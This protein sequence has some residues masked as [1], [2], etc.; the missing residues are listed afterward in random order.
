MNSLLVIFYLTFLL[1]SLFNNLRFIIIYIFLLGLYTYLTQITLFKTI[2]N[3]ARRKIMIGTW[4][5]PYDPQTY[6]K[7]KLEIS[8][9]EPYLEKKS[10]EI[11]EKITLTTFTVKLLSIV[12]KRHPELCG[13]IKFGKVN[14]KKK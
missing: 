11:G 8:K 13:F 14:F 6:C 10:S 2:I 12:L 9:I 7:V 5:T 1:Y 4:N 3:S